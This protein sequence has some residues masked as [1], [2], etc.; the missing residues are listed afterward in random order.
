[1]IVIICSMLLSPLDCPAFALCPHVEMSFFGLKG[2]LNI[3]P[4][5]V[6][7]AIFVRRLYMKKLSEKIE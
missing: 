7:F 2:Y 1:M 3:P 4:F 6:P 5:L